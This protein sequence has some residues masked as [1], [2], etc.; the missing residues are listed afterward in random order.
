MTLFLSVFGRHKTVSRT[1]NASTGLPC[2]GLGASR[3][4]LWDSSV[5]QFLKYTSEGADRV[6]ASAEH[7]DQ[8]MRARHVCATPGKTGTS[9]RL[10]LSL[11]VADSARRTALHS[12]A[13]PGV[14]CSA[15]GGRP[16]VCA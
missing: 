15:A 3:V 11:V 10:Q 13:T 5:G 14:R 12:E 6:H 4:R 16:L 1:V 8:V 7:G 2:Q 9:V